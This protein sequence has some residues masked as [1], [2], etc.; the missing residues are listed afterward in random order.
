MSNEAANAISDELGFEDDIRQ[1]FLKSLTGH[2]IVDPSD[3][4]LGSAAP[5][6]EQKNGQLMGSITSFP[7]LCIVNAAICRWSLEIGDQRVWSLR[8]APFCV[9]G[10]D[11]LLKATARTKEAWER[12]SSAAGLAPSVGKVYF[13][14]DFLNINSTTY[15]HSHIYPYTTS[16]VT[17]KDG[18]EALRPWYFRKVEY[19]NMGLLLGLKRSGGKVGLDEVGMEQ[20][21]LGARARDLV[22]NSPPSLRE[23][24]LAEFIH[25]HAE[26]LREV[27]APWFLPESVGGLGLPSAGRFSP[28]DRSLRLARA[29]LDRGKSP[30]QRP[31][32]ESWHTWEHVLKDFPV[33]TENLHQKLT[34]LYEFSA[35]VEVMTEQTL[36]GLAAVALLFRVVTASHPAPDSDPRWIPLHMRMGIKLTHSD[37]KGPIPLLGYPRLSDWKK[38]AEK[39]RVDDR[40]MYAQRLSD[41]WKPIRRLKT[42]PPPIPL[43]D[44]PKSL[45]F[46]KEPTMTI[47]PDVL[48]LE[49]TRMGNE[50][51]GP[52][53][54]R[55]STDTSRYSA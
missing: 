52:E 16:V 10:D 40:N 6:L 5:Y 54:L 31:S 32:L 22:S 55:H 17:R 45:S 33:N 8:D 47:A 23:T 34:T 37:D 50:L 2:Y 26:I 51:G 18:V 28:D 35:G 7:I 38:S 53:P 29:M 27:R 20:G 9:N 21:S 39:K 49:F 1:I 3:E 43:A 24:V 42:Y 19:V 36:R 15:T 25:R 46:T 13:S 30:P 44:I 41:F 48:I 11:G 12:I 14:R 4:D